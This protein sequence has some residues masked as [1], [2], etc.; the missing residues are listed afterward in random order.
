MKEVK[1]VC[2]HSE[3]SA[4]LRH[5]KHIEILKSLL[6]FS[7]WMHRQC[8]ALTIIWTPPREY[9]SFQWAWPLIQMEINTRHRINHIAQ[10]HFRQNKFFLFARSP[11]WMFYR[12]KIGSRILNANIFEWGQSTT[13][14]LLLL[15]CI[16]VCACVKS[17]L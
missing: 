9:N 12:W 14:D 16:C 11:S 3:C 7:F 1:V 17:H 8:N 15:F 10:T 6:F 13:N 4:F 5:T 2:R